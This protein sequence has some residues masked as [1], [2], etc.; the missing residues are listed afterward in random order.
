[1]CLVLSFYF[2][3]CQKTAVLDNRLEV[4]HWKKLIRSTSSFALGKKP[5]NFP[6]TVMNHIK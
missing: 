6:D 3:F 5:Q 4:K 1:M 2:P